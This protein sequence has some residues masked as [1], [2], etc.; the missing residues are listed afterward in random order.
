MLC[1]IDQAE[2]IRLLGIVL[3]MMIDGP[4]TG[5]SLTMFEMDVSPGAGMPVPHHHVGFDELA[6]GMAG[7]LRM[8]IEGQ[9]FEVGK[10]HSL[11]IKRGEVHSFVNPFDETAKVLCV[12]TPGVLGA[13]YFREV[14][15]LLVP[16]A[17][18]DPTKMAEVMMR[19]GLVP[20]KPALSR[21]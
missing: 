6:Y 8:T 17:P 12:L 5:A 9:A 14:R 15:E 16:G 10:G 3:R 11:L 19:H 2:E 20:A 13:Q 21:S 7:K 4:T 1:S 18:P